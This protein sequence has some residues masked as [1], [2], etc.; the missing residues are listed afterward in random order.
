MHSPLSLTG[1]EVILV[2]LI[3]VLVIGVLV[4]VLVFHNNNLLVIVS[5]AFSALVYVKSIGRNARCYYWKSFPFFD[6]GKLFT[7]LEDRN[8]SA[9]VDK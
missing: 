9:F 3:L 1:L 2:V 6:C 7:Y 4:L 5:A 8:A